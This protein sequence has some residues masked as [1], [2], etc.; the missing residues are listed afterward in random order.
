[1]QWQH[2]NRTPRDPGKPCWQKVGCVYVLLQVGVSCSSAM[3]VSS[4]V[5]LIQLLL[6]SGH[7][8]PQALTTFWCF[9][10]WASCFHNPLCSYLIHIT[11][12]KLKLT[13][14]LQQSLHL[15]KE[16]TDVHFHQTAVS[17][18]FLNCY[19]KVLREKEREE[20]CF[21]FNHRG[22]NHKWGLSFISLPIKKMVLRCTL[23]PV[24]HSAVEFRGVLLEKQKWCHVT[25]WPSRT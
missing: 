18:V 4:S 9:N 23:R 8:K 7:A 10:L 1:M 19:L 3:E 20:T 12:Y 25:F 21:W 16:T 24:V 5:T 22:A 14:Y 15:I 6:L 17:D 2:S 11:L 13:F